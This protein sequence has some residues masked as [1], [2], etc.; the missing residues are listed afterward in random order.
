MKQLRVYND[1]SDDNHKV[2]KHDVSVIQN[3]TPR[4]LNSI[5]MIN[6]ENLQITYK[7]IWLILF[8]KFRK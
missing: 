8:L 6:K 5:P 1:V 2:T 4:S 3:I 7:G